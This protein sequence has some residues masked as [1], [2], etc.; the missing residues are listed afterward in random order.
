MDALLWTAGIVLILLG[1]WLVMAPRFVPLGV[2]LFAAGVAVG[3]VWVGV[4][5]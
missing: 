2:L 1:A 4:F 3:P 5:Y